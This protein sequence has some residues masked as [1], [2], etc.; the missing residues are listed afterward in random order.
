MT[1]LDQNKTAVLAY[2][3]AFNRLDLPRLREL[4]TPDATIHGVLGS[5]GF[6]VAVGHWTEIHAAF[7]IQLQVD[8]IVAEGDRV[9]VRYAESGRFVGA[10]RGHPPTRRPYA[11]VSMEWFTMRDGLIAQRWASRDSGTQARQMGLSLG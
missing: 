1:I 10:F 2:V 4:F 7:A 3:E 8:D 5:G 11:I 6:D 9:V